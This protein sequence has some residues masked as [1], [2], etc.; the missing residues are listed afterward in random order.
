MEAWDGVWEFGCGERFADLDGNTPQMPC[1]P[2]EP[3]LVHDGRFFLKYLLLQSSCITRTAFQDFCHLSLLNN[4]NP[5]LL[6]CAPGCTWAVSFPSLS[7]P[8]PSL[9]PNPAVAILGRFP[10]PGFSI[11]LHLHYIPTH[12]HFCFPSG[13]S[14][15]WRLLKE[16][17]ESKCHVILVTVHDMSHIFI[18]VACP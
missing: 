12:S 6:V 5:R 13:H 1:G 16:N 3:A 15:G 2:T 18:F 10:Y 8:G 11:S 9:F 4:S 7:T 17:T 14:V